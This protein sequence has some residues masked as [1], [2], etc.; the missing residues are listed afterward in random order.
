MIVIA[1]IAGFARPM[2]AQP[3]SGSVFQRALTA[4]T[5]ERDISK[6]IDLYKEALRQFPSMQPWTGRALLHLG[7]CYERVGRLKEAVLVY[8]SILVRTGIA[9]EIAQEARADVQRLEGQMAALLNPTDTKS[10]LAGF[11]ESAA[12]QKDGSVLRWGADPL[13]K[14]DVRPSYVEDVIGATAVA[15]GPRQFLWIN[16]DGAV[17]GWDSETARNLPLA[18]SATIGGL[19][20]VV[21]VGCGGSHQLALRNDG[22]VWGW[23]M[24]NRGQ[25]GDDTL[26]RRV[27]PVWIGGITG[28]VAIAAGE[29]HSI[30]LTG[31]GTVF[32][33]GANDVG[34]LGIGSDIALIPHPK[35][36]P[37]SR[38]IV[39]VAAGARHSIAMAG[40]GTVWTWGNNADGEL[41]DGTN[42][43][44][45]D[46]VQVA[47]LSNVQ[48]IA[49]GPAY[50]VALRSDGTVWAWGDNRYGQLG[51]GNTISRAIP[52]QVSGLVNI[53]AISAGAGHNLAVRRDGTV[54]AWGRND[55]GQLGDG[56]T[57]N[58][59]VPV[60]ISSPSPAG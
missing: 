40:D 2:A 10:V 12:V 53:Q 58:R 20:D 37:G 22:S 54:W 8:R 23:G 31:D 14:S 5:D 1:L 7:S 15:L 47:H 43:S 50:T 41:G 3:S 16:Q 11:L 33:W 42:Q 27:R 49:A 51:D 17:M 29:E 59:L 18:S 35:Y 32:T 39:A 45:H 48:A 28:V 25:V 30:A 6:A 52:V 9:T 34:Q 21:M 60:Q 44:S 4:E 36:V 56:T 26:S 13:L 46:P 24:N 57:H 19:T 38:G 55:M